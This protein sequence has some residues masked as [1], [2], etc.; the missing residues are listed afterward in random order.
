MATTNPTNLTTYNVPALTVFFCSVFGFQ[1]LSRSA[2]FLFWSS[3][4]GFSGPSN[5]FHLSN[6]KDFATR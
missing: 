6:L 3:P 2:H 4:Q 5:V 1:G